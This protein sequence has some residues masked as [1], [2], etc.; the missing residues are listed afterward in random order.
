LGIFARLRDDDA[1][2][3]LSTL[4]FVRGYVRLNPL[5]ANA[6]LAGG[7]APRAMTIGSLAT[8]QIGPDCAVRLDLATP[9]HRNNTSAV[10]QPTR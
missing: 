1:R 2:R 7:L 5:T 4:L 6:S 9:L 8:T 10:A 3:R